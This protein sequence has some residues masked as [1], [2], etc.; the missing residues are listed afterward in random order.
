MDYLCFFIKCNKSFNLDQKIKVAISS[1]N[2]KG[3]FSK[4]NFPL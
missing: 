3:I 4:K 2:E 1:F